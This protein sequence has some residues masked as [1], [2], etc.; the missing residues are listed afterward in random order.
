MRLDGRQCVTYC[1]SYTVVVGF[2]F[3][4]SWKSFTCAPCGY[5]CVGVRPNVLALAIAHSHKNTSVYMVYI[6]LYAI[7]S[8]S[9]SKQQQQKRN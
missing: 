8:C 6:L 4:G 5:Y 3:V 9:V 1:Q 7:T 2:V